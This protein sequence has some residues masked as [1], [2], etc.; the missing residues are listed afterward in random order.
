MSRSAPAG[1]AVHPVGSPSPPR[2]RGRRSIG[3]LGAALLA[4]ASVAAAS[5]R[6]LPERLTAA[7]S[8]FLSSLA[9]EQRAAASFPFDDDERF[10]LRL[11]P[12]F[13]DGLRM[14]RLDEAQEEKLRGFL[15]TALSTD[16]R[17]KV[18]TIMS[19]EHEV[20]SLERR[21]LLRWPVQFV[22]DPKRYHIAVFGEP[23]HESPWG[24]RFDGHHVSLNFTVVP[25]EAPSS[26]PLFL[27]AQPRE[28]PAGFERAG[29]R[30]LAEE[31][32]I[33]RRLYLSLEGELRERAT[34]PFASGRGLFLGEGRRV[35]LE[36]APSGLPRG[37]MPEAA[38]QTLDALLEVYLGLLASE[39][40]SARRAGIEEAGRDGIHF[41]WAGGTASGEPSYYR[42]RGP[43]FLIEFDNTLAG[44]DHVHAIWR[45]F[46]GDFGED[47][48]A[49]HYELA[50]GVED[51][52]R[53]PR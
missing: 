48:L 43:S 53:L 1:C 52:E 18:E 28:V 45:D 51:P 15:A 47:L 7:A 25:G 29:L 9:P 34:I 13:L 21:S 33:A 38:R 41:A 20:A 4:L 42:I 49:R 12:F 19:L 24:F 8:A 39:I 32:E 36:G 6:P 5:T 26:T 44:A 35:A 14:S 16:G 2:R 11:I 27:G 31:E 17:R 23:S 22:R 46:E 37:E 10:D 3:A 40:A 30:V 50:H